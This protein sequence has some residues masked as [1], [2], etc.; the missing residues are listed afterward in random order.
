MIFRI[1]HFKSYKRPPPHDNDDDDNNN[2]N[3]IISSI[4]VMDIAYLV[5]GLL[6][7]YFPASLLVV[8]S[9]R[10]VFALTAVLPIPSRNHCS[11]VYRRNHTLRRR[12]KTFCLCQGTSANVMGCSS[13]TGNLALCRV[14]MCQ[15]HTSEQEPN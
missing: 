7:A 15:R 5:G 9:V 1:Q 6:S 12:T 8:M 3:N 10:D 2:N 13:T 14:V 11:A 4:Q